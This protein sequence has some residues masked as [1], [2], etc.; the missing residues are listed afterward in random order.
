MKVEGISPE[1]M[2]E[3]CFFQFQSSTGIPLLEE[4]ECPI[5]CTDILA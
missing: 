2:L 1:F 3:K 4:G 5:I